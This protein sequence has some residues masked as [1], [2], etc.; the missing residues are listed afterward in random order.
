MV[1]DNPEDTG[2]PEATVKRRGLFSPIWLIPIIAAAVGGWLAFKT[3]SEKGPTIKITFSEVS[4]VEVGKTQIKVKD[5]T[6]GVVTDVELSDDLSTIT[7]TAEMVALAG[8]HLNED[9]RF[10]IVRPRFSASGVTGLDTL[11]SGAF[12][13][14]D[15][16]GG[17]PTTV[18]DG[19]E[20]PPQIT[21]DVPGKE[22]ILKSE[23]LGSLTP[24]SPIY[25]R[26][27]RVGQVLSFE[28]NAD[29]QG[30]SIPFFV[31]D[32]FAELVRDNSRFWNVSGITGTL[33][34]SGISV[35]TQSLASLISGGVTFQT[36][37]KAMDE[38]P[39]AEKTEF[40]LYNSLAA[41]LEA[42]FVE[43]E[44]FVVHFQDSVRG[45]EVNAPVEFRGIRIGTVTDIKMRVDS[46]QA[47]VTIP[48]TIDIEPQRFDEFYEDRATNYEENIGLWIARGLRAQL[49]SGNLI[50]G[51][52]FVDLDLYPDAEPATVAF[53]DGVPIIPSVSAAGF[54]EVTKSATA[55]LD[56]IARL[57][58][59]EVVSELQTTLKS[60][61][62]L[63]SS[64]SLRQAVDSLDQIGPILAGIN[65]TV[66]KADAT[67]SEAQSTFEST[68]TLMAKD[69]A[70][71]TDLRALLREL[72]DAARSA[73]VLTDYLE[74]HPEALIQG[75]RG[76]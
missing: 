4:G 64:P 21:S 50:T 14:M 49:R 31:Q 36:P 51:A 57:P 62:A 37:S 71:Q 75:K 17:E 10:W 27:L 7:L 47:K 12:I 44:E 29:A 22:F 66:Q 46:S 35:S 42:G 8:R 1:S 67:L 11:L 20:T 48:V 30:V 26:G 5:L 52:L 38:E 18:F 39:S 73:R 32:P 70:L 40:T 54:G 58:L 34:A 63:L 25:F 13:Q 2:L 28:L 60:T 3:I 41:V 76:Q 53:D 68:S 23:D 65:S 56:K 45:L 43:K 61:N 69:S 55:V 59:P 6:A 9:T 24:G 15:P 33:T 74:R 19:L 72:R 16:G